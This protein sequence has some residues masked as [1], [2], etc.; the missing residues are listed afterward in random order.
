MLYAATRSTM[1]A[2]FGSGQIR[3]EIFGTNVVWGFMTIP[4]CLNISLFVR[5]W[6]YFQKQLSNAECEVL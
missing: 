5:F 1:K 6:V 2:E 4:Y 3:Y